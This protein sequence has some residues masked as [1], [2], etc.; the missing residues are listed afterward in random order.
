[1]S[2]PHIPGTGFTS[3]AFGLALGLAG[4]GAFLAFGFLAGGFFMEFSNFE[5]LETQPQTLLGW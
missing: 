5:K 1:L 3:I 4:F 2:F